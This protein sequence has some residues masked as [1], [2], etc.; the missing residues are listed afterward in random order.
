MVTK[1]P[2]LNP[3]SHRADLELRAS[4]LVQTG[5][6][7]STR[8]SYGVGVRSFMEFAASIELS[9]QPPFSEGLLC[10]Y[11]AFKAGSVEADTIRSYITAIRSWHIDLGHRLDTSEMPRLQR[12]IKGAA[13][14]RPGKLVKRAPPVTM[15]AIT[16]IGE[17]I[18][19]SDY[20][21][22]SRMAIMTLA[23]AGMFRLGEL[24]PKRK[25]KPPRLTADR[26]WLS[27]RGVHVHL[28]KS[29][30]DQL[31]ARGPLLIVKNGTLACPWLWCSWLWRMRPKP[32]LGPA[33]V[34]S[35]GDQASREW[36]L[37]EA[38]RLL[39]R[40]GIQD[41]TPTGH[42]FRRGGTTSLAATGAP[43]YLIAILGRWKASTLQLYV[44]PSQEQLA[45]A[46]RAMALSPCLFGEMRPTA[47]YG[48]ARPPRASDWESL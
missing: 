44:E 7:E 10:L 5:L 16:R 21:E 18:D 17:V 45:A 37:Q 2:R 27:E 22:V 20:N 14:L 8:E 29:K 25:T 46:Q 19:R 11:V 3:N 48:R 30:T 41:L 4:E 24:I 28:P 40:A 42:S 6:A 12:A 35:E 15:A 33:F 32:V 31:G 13:K 43:D 26:I 47:P 36:V 23:T 9:P 1:K 38:T 39:M 34:T